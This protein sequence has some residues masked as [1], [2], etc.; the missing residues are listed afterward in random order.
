MGE[1]FILAEYVQK[2]DI[3]IVVYDGDILAFSSEA[4]L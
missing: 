4:Y 1:P 2:N 3:D